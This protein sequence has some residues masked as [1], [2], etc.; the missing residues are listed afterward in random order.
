M[1]VMNG[2]G[3]VAYRPSYRGLAMDLAG[4]KPSPR[5]DAWPTCWNR[6]VDVAGSQ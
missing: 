4:N 1:F 2:S 3:I 6:L 5:V